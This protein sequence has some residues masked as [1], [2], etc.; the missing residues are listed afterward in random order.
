MP[1][2]LI[3]F[4]CFNSPMGVLFCIALKKTYFIHT[5]QS[6]CIFLL[7]ITAKKV[8]VSKFATFIGNIE[9]MLLGRIFELVS[10]RNVPIS[11]VSTVFDA[12]E[13][14]WHQI[15]T[16]CASGSV[17]ALFAILI[18]NLQGQANSCA[19]M[20]NAQNQIIICINSHTIQRIDSFCPKRKSD[21]FI[22][23]SFIPRQMQYI[24]NNVS[25][26]VFS[27]A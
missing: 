12:T 20:N 6:Y 21:L 2:N 9:F 13:G 18:N 17:P 27:F 7:S 1:L 26:W 14:H 19:L 23:Y 15:F 24:Q 3:R 25:F 16:S 8:H 10:G 11:D 22:V 5:P 4:S